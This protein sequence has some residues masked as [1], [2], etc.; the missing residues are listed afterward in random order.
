[1]KLPLLLLPLLVA[2]PVFA[3]DKVSDILRN[4]QETMT[5]SEALE[6]FQAN[7]RRGDATAW[8]K[9]KA[10]AI[11]AGRGMKVETSQGLVDHVEPGVF[12]EFCN[13]TLELLPA[14]TQ[15]LGIVRDVR[16][17][18]VYLEMNVRGQTQF[19]SFPT[20]SFEGPIASGAQ[21][22]VDWKTNGVAATKLSPAKTG[23]APAKITLIDVDGMMF[24]QPEI[25]GAPLLAAKSEKVHD[26]GKRTLEQMNLHLDSTVWVKWN[27]ETNDVESVVP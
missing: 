2:L 18:R 22:L 11:A 15:S 27:P 10:A 5:P 19:I 17:L 14:E 16:R 13:L 6:H 3:S 25:E 4:Y 8:P 9:A 24:L 21:F 23:S 1:M 20:K 26:L 7:R 12:Q